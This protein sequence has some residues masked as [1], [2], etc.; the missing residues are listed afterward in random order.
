MAILLYSSILNFSRSIISSLCLCKV[1]KLLHA[2]SDWFLLLNVLFSLLL[3][4]IQ[5]VRSFDPGKSHVTFYALTRATKFILFPFKEHLDSENDRLINGV[6]ELGS[7]IF[8]CG[9]FKK[10]E[11]KITFQI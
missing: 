1:R 10:I 4:I 7:Y 6:T 9:F 8:F 2:C 11:K 5:F 3:W